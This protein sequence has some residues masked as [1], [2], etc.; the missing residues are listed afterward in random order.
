[1]ADWLPQMSQD[2][3]RAGINTARLGRWDIW[4]LH[5]M[6]SDPAHFTAEEIS[7]SAQRARILAAPR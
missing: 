6:L 3:S 4:V 1:M 5:R 2:L 7:A